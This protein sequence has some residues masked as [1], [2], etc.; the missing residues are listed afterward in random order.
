MSDLREIIMGKKVGSTACSLSEAPRFVFHSSFT[1]PGAAR[2]LG[3]DRPAGEESQFA[4]AYMPD[5]ITRDCARRMHYAAYRCSKARSEED[6]HRWHQLYFRLRDKIILG[7]RKL[8]FRAVRKWT[9]EQNAA[10]DLVGECYLVLIRVVAAYN[11][12]LGIRFS[13]YAFTCLM[14]ALS[15][16]NQR[17]LADR[18]ER[19][20]SLDNLIDQH[21]AHP[22]PG[23][24]QTHHGQMLDV[25]LRDEHPLLSAREKTILLRRFHLVGPE[26]TSTLEKVGEDLGI[27]KERV[28]QVQAT[29]LGKLRQVMLSPAEAS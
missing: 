14:R 21:L 20:L 1:E 29:A 5:E 24:N 13:T 28:R 7:N 2:L 6:K 12:W 19:H 26:E 9:F 17:S 10:D 16:N 3:K 27:S 22:V 25:Y 4:L 18:L 23:E 11:P 8:I 15:R